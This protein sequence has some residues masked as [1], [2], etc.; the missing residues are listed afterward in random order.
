MAGLTI[1]DKEALKLFKEKLMLEFADQVDSVQ[2]FGSKARG[3]A[4]KFSDVDVLVVLKDSRGANRRR[5]SS[6]T[7]RV[8]TDTGV[9]LSPVTLSP[10]QLKEL[11]D[12]RSMFWQAIGPDL[13]KV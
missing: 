11:Q 4:T 7:S 10:Q 6:I 3:E 9:F 13:Q 12:H 1:K 2:L 8:L 5:V